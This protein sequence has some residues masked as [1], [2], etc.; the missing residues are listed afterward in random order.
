M[1]P[2]QGHPLKNTTL[3]STDNSNRDSQQIQLEKISELEQPTL[4]P[5][6]SFKNQKTNQKPYLL[7][8]NFKSILATDHQ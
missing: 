3:S 1:G 5:F 8:G 4:P 7:S 2:F 6:S